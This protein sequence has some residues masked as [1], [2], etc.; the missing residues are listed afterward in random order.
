M[1]S[2][3]QEVNGLY[4]IVEMKL[5]R[6]TPGVVFDLYPMETIP[7]IDT[8]DRVLH[9]KG[10]VSPGPVGDHQ[11][12]WYMHEHQADNLIVLHGQRTV[13]LYTKNHGRVEEFIVRPDEIYHN[14]ELVVKGGAVLGWPT[15]VFHHIIS[16]DNGSASL[17][18]AVHYEGFNIRSNFDV[19]SLDT[20]TG[21]YQVIRKGYEDQF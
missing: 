5:F 2:I 14:G 13:H 1:S 20:E 18:L 9:E 10:A 11:K 16:G 21:D 8:I 12:S 17:N 3:I 6:K 15:H 19:F 4:R 7:R